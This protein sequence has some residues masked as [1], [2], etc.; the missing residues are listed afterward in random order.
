VPLRLRGTVWRAVTVPVAGGAE[1][2]APPGWTAL[3]A[4]APGELHALRGRG[5][6]GHGMA[7]IT[8]RPS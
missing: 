4:A 1:A 2:V 7:E 6:T 8:R 3:P 5:R